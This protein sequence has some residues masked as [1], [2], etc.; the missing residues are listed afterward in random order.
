LQAEQCHL[1]AE[2][3]LPERTRYRN[4]GLPIAMPLMTNAGQIA[5]GTLAPAEGIGWRGGRGGRLYGI[6]FEWIVAGRG[7]R[8][9]GWRSKWSRRC[10]WGRAI[11]SRSKGIVRVGGR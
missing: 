6:I 5:C 1:T 7:R 4:Y 9:S 8:S 11:V 2:A 3:R 10:G